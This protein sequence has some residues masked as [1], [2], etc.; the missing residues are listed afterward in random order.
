[1]QGIEEAA[2]GEVSVRSLQDLHA[3]LAAWREGKP[4]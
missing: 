3:Q 1:V 2:R 4:A